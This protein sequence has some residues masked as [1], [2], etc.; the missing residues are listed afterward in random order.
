MEF[1]DGSE[2]D[3]T[4]DMWPVSSYCSIF[5]LDGFGEARR[6]FTQDSWK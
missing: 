2:D 3:E 5:F 4:R 6:N 1:N